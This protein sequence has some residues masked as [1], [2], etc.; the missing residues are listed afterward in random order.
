[1]PVILTEAA[2]RP[3]VNSSYLSCINPAN[4]QC[5]QQKYS[6]KFSDCKFGLM[7]NLYACEGKPGKVISLIWGS[8]QKMCYHL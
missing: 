6:D 1:M 7:G 8:L 3:A 4:G 2:G 5:L